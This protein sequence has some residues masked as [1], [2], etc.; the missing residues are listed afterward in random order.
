[1]LDAQL[2][3][4]PFC[5]SSDVVICKR[6]RYSSIPE[7]LTAWCRGCCA[8]EVGCGTSVAEHV[9]KAWNRR[10]AKNPGGDSEHRDQLHPATTGL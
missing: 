2:L 7:Q 3:P 8:V 5:G 10:V 6:H 9:I 4:C 1:M